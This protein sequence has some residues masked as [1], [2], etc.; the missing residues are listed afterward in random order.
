MLP[1]EYPR[2]QKALTVSEAA[3]LFDRSASWVRDEIA[4]GRLKTLHPAGQRPVRV[5][6]TSVKALQR[7]ILE[8]S[9]ATEGKQ[10]PV[11]RLVVDNTK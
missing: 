4:G 10:L 1:T 3:A 9:R 2:D 8:R 6:E 7:F 5:T 11:L